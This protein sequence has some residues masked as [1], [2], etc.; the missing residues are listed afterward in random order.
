[1]QELSPKEQHTDQSQSSIVQQ[2]RLRVKRSPR[3]AN[4]LYRYCRQSGLGPPFCLKY[5]VQM[6][7]AT[8]H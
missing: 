8:G 5:A 2:D 3:N 1:M 6:I 7:L 4:I